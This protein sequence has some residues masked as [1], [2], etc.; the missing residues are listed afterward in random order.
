MSLFTNEKGTVRLSAKSLSQEGYLADT[1]AF[2]LFQRTTFDS[3]TN[4]IA[5]KAG[6]FELVIDAKELTP[7]QAAKLV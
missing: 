1:P 3:Q 5:N 4:T 2:T 6:T 7:A